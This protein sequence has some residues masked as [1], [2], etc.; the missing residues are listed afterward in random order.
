MTDSQ[1]Y[2]ETK[3][4]FY[5]ASML[6]LSIGIRLFC[7]WTLSLDPI[8][9]RSINYTNIVWFANYWLMYCIPLSS[10]NILFIFNITAENTRYLFSLCYR[11]FQLW[12]LH[13]ICVISQHEILASVT[14]LHFAVPLFPLDFPLLRLNIS[15]TLRTSKI[16][17]PI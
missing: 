11:L 3:P 2:Y 4:R 15:Y 14:T 17:L 5:K 13:R 1:I 16:M 6:N 8:V 12:L 7:L 9:G 10:N